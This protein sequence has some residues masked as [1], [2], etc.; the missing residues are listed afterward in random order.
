M[1]GRALIAP[2]RFARRVRYSGADRVPIQVV[3]YLRRPAAALA[4]A[5]PSTLRTLATVGVWCVVIGAVGGFI[6]SGVQGAPA[7]ERFL[8]PLW[9]LVWAYARLFILRTSA[10]RPLKDDRV[11]LNAAWGAA[12]VPYLLAVTPSL[13]L[14]AFAASAWYTWRGVHGAGATNSR[15]GAMVALAYGGQLAVEVATWFARAGA[16]LFLLFLGG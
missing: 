5:G 3:S 15:A 10:P 6:F 2:V 12:L 9:T 13:R 1:L 14:A 11:L 16:Y 7:A 4:V 8:A